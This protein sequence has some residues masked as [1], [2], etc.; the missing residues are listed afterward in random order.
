MRRLTAFLSSALFAFTTV[1]ATVITND[2]SAITGSFEYII[3]GGGTAALA[4]ANRL[5]VNH[6]VLVIERG[7][8]ER[9]N[10]GINNPMTIN[11]VIP[12]NV[13][14]HQVGNSP[15]QVGS[16]GTHV[17][18]Q[19]IQ[20]GNCLGG[21]SSVNTMIGS[22]PTLA[23]MNA[24]EALGNP[25]WGWDDFLPFMQ[26]SET[27]NS[28][29]AQQ[30]AQGA[31]FNASVHGT[32]GPVGVSFANPLLAPQVQFAAKN[33]TENVYGVTLTDDMGDGFSGGHLASS[34][35]HIHFNETLQK[36]RRSSSA[37]SYLYPQ[38]QQRSN[39]MVLTQHTVNTVV[40]VNGTDGNLT[41]TGVTLVPTNGSG[42]MLTFNATREVIVS[43]GAPFSPGVLQRSGI[44]NSTFLQSLGITPVLDLPVGSNFQ[45]QTLFVNISFPIANSFRSN[46]N[47][48]VSPVMLGIVVAHATADEAFGNNGNQMIASSIRSTVADRAISTGGIVNAQSMVVQANVT[49]NAFEI[50]HP[51]L[52]L[53]FTPGGELSV[54]SQSVLPMSRGTVRINTTDPLA[55][56]MVDAQYL[57]ADI[58]VQIFTRAARRLG[59]IASTPP[60]SN[61]LTDSAYAQSGLPA[62][63]ASDDEWRTWTLDHYSP[64]VHF[65]GS[66]S[67]MPK[68]LGG[69]VSPQL[70]VYGTTNLRVADASIMPLSVFPHCT[71]GLYGVAE[72]AADM[73][74]Q[75]ASGSAPN[76][77]SSSGS[78]TASGTASNTD[79][80]QPPG[81][82]QSTD[83]SAQ[84]F[85]LYSRLVMLFVAVL[86]FLIEFV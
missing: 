62:V 79:S 64:G 44:G 23:G 18:V 17:R 4:I 39:L 68:E 70:L 77:G 5:S 29:N 33:T 28:P 22:R 81:P 34:Y 63:D 24:V 78:S 85:C 3:V 30:V 7:T 58:D 26:R 56:P 55:F 59:M 47:V 67:M 25:G 65:I 14:C 76:S 49:A 12:A 13:T 50:D 42:S 84:G 54:W 21:G 41:A 46:P 15:P 69:V 72:K 27:F 82:S 74:L 71:L 2:S 36:Q 83:N 32:S 60:F 66:N 19:T 48:S 9:D 51:L 57:T 6:T 10:E 75:T 80:T 31:S 35:Y 45:D 52:E 86:P 1:G 37:W 20:Y 73:I 16:N 8:D 61:L 38:D 11:G 53:F 43:A 40:T